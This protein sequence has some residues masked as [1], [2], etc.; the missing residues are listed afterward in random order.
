M[1]F[2]T[3]EELDDWYDFVN[4]L[5]VRVSDTDTPTIAGKIMKTIKESYGNK[6]SRDSEIDSGSAG[7]QE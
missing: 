3:E 5:K 7:V 6:D 1:K 2:E 4:D